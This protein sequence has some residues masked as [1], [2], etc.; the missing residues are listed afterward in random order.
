MAAD[1]GPSLV[2]Y[3]LFRSRCCFPAAGDP[4]EVPQTGPNGTMG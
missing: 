2:P 1:N 3:Q 4:G